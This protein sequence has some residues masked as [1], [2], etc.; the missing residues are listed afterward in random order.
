M[1][2][3]QT[4]EHLGHFEEVFCQTTGRMLGT[5]VV[6]DPGD[7][8]LGYAGTM[9]DILVTAPLTLTRGH[10]TVTFPASPEKPLKVRTMLQVICGR[11]LSYENRPQVRL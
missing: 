5:R 1:N 8:K 6:P 4:F 2:G 10:K 7:R 9:E 3:N 11:L